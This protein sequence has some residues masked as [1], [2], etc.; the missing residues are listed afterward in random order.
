MEITLYNQIQNPLD[1]IDRLGNWFA[2]SGMTGADN[3]NAGKILA[4]ECLAQ[5]KSPTQILKRYDIIGGKLRDKAISIYADF[6]ALGG[7]VE[8]ISAMDDDKEANAKLTFEGQT[9]N[10]TFTIEMAQ[11]QGLVRP[12][13]GW[14]KNP[15]NMLRAR[16]LTN[17][18]AML[19]PEITAGDDSIGDAPEVAAPAIS[20]KVESVAATDAAIPR[21]PAQPVIEAE[22][23]KESS[24]AVPAP[25]PPPA[26]QTTPAPSPTTATEPVAAA[27]VSQPAAASTLPGLPDELVARVEQAIGE[28]AVAA[29]R[30]LVK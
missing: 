12:G 8:W 27:P 28:H 22:V 21:A 14:V 29:G 23:V 10:A 1:A 13:S 2:K 24:P 16:L 17:G 11:K 3:E 18:I 9:I 6:R 4:W 5:K 26:Q 19:A 20:L 30:W 25:T 15:S 7:K